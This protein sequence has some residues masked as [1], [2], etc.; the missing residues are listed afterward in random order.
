MRDQPLLV[1]KRCALALTAFFC[2]AANSL[3]QSTNVA[4]SAPPDWVR[5]CDWGL[6]GNQP[7]RAKAE[8]SRY[9]LYER[10]QN[11]ARK[12]SFTRVILLM[13][14][15]TGVQDS[16]SLSFGFDPSFQELLLHRVQIH[17]DGKALERLDRSKVRII[18][19]EPDLDG[20][21]FT[22][23]QTA[24]LFVEDLRIGDALEY[25]YTVRGANPILK[26][27][28]AARFVVQSGVPMDRE[29]LR[30]IW[31]A[32]K[33]LYLRQ[34][35]TAVAPRLE[36]TDDGTAR[37]W[38]F[39]NLDAIPYEDDLPASYEP[40]PY[41]ELSD[42]DGWSRVVEWALPLYSVGR[43]NLPS[44]LQALVAKWQADAVANEE[45]ARS[46]LT[47]VQ[48]ELRYTGIELG[49]DSYRPNQPSETFRLRYGDCKAKALLLCTLLREMNIEA[50][51]ALV[52]TLDRDAVA[53][54]LPSPFAF[55][56]V[57]VKL[58]LDGKAVWVDPTRSYQGGSLWERF[59]PPLG[60]ALVLNKGVTAL[61]DIPPSG[62]SPLQR[63]TST[64]R[65]KYYDSPASLEVKTVYHGSGAD[66][67]R[68]YLARTDPEE[69]A[70]S[71]LNFYARYY[72][73]VHD[74]RPLDVNDQRTSN[75][76]EVTEHYQV[77]DFWK[78]DKSK[79]RWEANLFAESLDKMLTDPDTRLRKMPLRIPYPMRREQEVVVFLPDDSWSISPAD[80]AVECEVFSFHYRRKLSGSIARFQYDCETKA[81]AVAAEKVATYFKKLDEMKD[82]LGEILTRPDDRP[83][84]ALSRLNWPMIVVA[85]FG[86]VATLAGCLWV[87]RVTRLT[88]AALDASLS[89]ALPED[90]HLRGLGG[91]LIVVGFGLCYGLVWRPIDLLQNWEGFFSTL[92]W[93]AVAI[94]G[95]EKYHPL[96]GPL[97]IFE[98]LC[99]TLMIGL[100]V[101]AVCLFFA[102]RK[103]FPRIYIALLVVNAAFLL[104][105]EILGA[106]IPVTETSDNS[107]ATD[108]FRAIVQALI[109]CS[110]AL[111][112]RRV[113]VTFVR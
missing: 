56:H 50:H 88:G 15:Q 72:A 64:F 53:T 104:T 22:G 74:L 99:N 84:T 61:E 79:Q 20:H 97:L 73:G 107:S 33:P 17:R 44:D 5:L 48:D 3:G 32:A 31:P 76:L 77:R 49:P 70:K 6:P 108:V 85:G 62:A 63:V 29:Y 111:K 112:S 9:L 95:G 106:R 8:G 58:L 87:W 40:Y 1:S 113:K 45:R 18:Q 27:H 26:G 42:F 23:R 110:Y 98:V 25:S 43:T 30:V 13:E 96:Y 11:P 71:Y 10:Q 83:G 89:A 105:D 60:K 66:S 7:A 93:Q 109:W 94:P 65:L 12:E 14:N 36:P 67:M 2:L 92:G 59:L 41:V 19:P 24:V 16:G 4:V 37:V 100:N 21:V 47:F 78:L 102:R 103:A 68:E 34:H 52:N 69:I 55:N 28:Y 82:L 39:A 35:S 90:S 46:A 80:Q 86:L 54:R 51:P 91:W 75:V 38:D 81:P 101:L 57:I